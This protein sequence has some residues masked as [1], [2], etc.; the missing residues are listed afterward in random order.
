MSFMSAT[1]DSA[2]STQGSAF[3]RGDCLGTKS[4][5]LILQRGYLRSRVQCHDLGL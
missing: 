2:P 1:D 5:T 3:T 4:H